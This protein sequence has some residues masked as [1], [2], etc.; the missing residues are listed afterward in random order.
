MVDGLKDLS[1][2]LK[3][4]ADGTAPRLRK[5]LRAAGA[6]VQRQAQDNASW[7]SKIPPTIKVGVTQTAVTVYTKDPQARSY[8]TDGKH[9]V[10]PRRRLPRKRWAWN[11]KPL[12]R[13]FLFPAADHKANEVAQAV[14]DAVADITL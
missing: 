5:G 2:A 9:P 1:K 12:K 6:I 14:L 8:E 13:P 11:K 4:A 10:F 7:S 3:A